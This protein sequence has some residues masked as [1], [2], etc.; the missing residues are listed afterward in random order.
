MSSAKIETIAA[1]VRKWAEQK[2]ANSAQH[3][4]DLCGMCAIASAKLFS[5][6]EKSGID[7]YIAINVEESHCFVV[8]PMN[9]N[10]ELV[11]DVTATQFGS[12]FG[13]VE[14]Q[15]SY[16]ASNKVYWQIGQTFRSVRALTKYQSNAGWP[17]FQIAQAPNI[18]EYYEEDYGDRWTD[19]DYE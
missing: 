19:N 18:R 12:L 10:F 2:A 16:E 15:D 11:V 17:K 6:L 5:E 3:S 7:S 9:D 14:I 13:P 1:R 8:V 4:P